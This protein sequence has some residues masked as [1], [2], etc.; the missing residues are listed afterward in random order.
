MSTS[1]AAWAVSDKAASLHRQTLV[2]DNHGCM[3]IKDTE[4]FLGEQSNTVVPASTW[5]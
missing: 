5:P 3:P 1:S 2:W 4:R